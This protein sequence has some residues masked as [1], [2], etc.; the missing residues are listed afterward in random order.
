MRIYPQETEFIVGQSLTICVQPNCRFALKFYKQTSGEKIQFVSGIS[1][2]SSYNV[3]SNLINGVYVFSSGNGP[4]VGQ[5]NADWQWPSVTFKP[6]G[7]VASAPYIV[8]AYEVNSNGEPVTAFGREM[9]NTEPVLPYP[10]NS[11]SMALVVGRPSSPVN[12]AAYII[13]VATYHAYNSIGGGCF[14][15]DHVHNYPATTQVTMRRPG[16]GLGALFGE[17]DDFYDTASPRQQFSHWD[18][19]FIRYLQSQN[20][21]ADYYTDVSLHAGSIQL[22]RYK[23]LISVGHHEYWSQDMRNGVSSYI[24]Q[25]GNVAVFS[26][27]TCYRPI[28]FGYYRTSSYM[29]EVNKLA[30]NWPNYNESDLLGLSFGFGGGKWGSWN[31]Q[32]KQWTN[33]SR[34][35]IGYEVR[36]ASHWVFSGTG[37]TNATTFGAS[38][39]L[40]G[41]EADGIPL[42][43][44]TFNL[45][46][47]SPVPSGWDEVHGPGALGIYGHESATGPKRGLV[48]NCGTTDWARILMDDTASSHRA[49]RI[50]TH[51]VLTAFGA[52]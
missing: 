11:D 1:L 22:D 36:N 52:A 12:S 29:N 26:G 25:G 34:D 10:P 31:E 20:I 45:L 21:N 15:T 40:V 18:A 8:I 9:A 32:T 43:G 47:Q 5:Y 17:P 39:R 2:T 28:N 42:S 13:P 6:R 50:I 41:Y 37:L 14:Y 4:A 51:N 46:A 33:T 16:G 24:A 19:K 7:V 38:D 48:F 44:S 27:N 35:P 23:C 3:Q 30:E 49:V